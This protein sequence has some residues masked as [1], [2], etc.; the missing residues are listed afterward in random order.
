[1][2]ASVST[3]RVMDVDALVHKVQDE[4]VERV[5]AIEGFVGYFVIDGTDGTAVAIALGETEEAVAASIVEA[6]QWVVQS[7]AH[8]VEGA[9]A[10]TAGEVRVRAER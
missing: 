9:P 10:L 1:M 8:L 7:A 2:H 6:Q 3:Y 4:L 5:K